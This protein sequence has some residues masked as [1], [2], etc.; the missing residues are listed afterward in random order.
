MKPIFFHCL[1]VYYKSKNLVIKFVNAINYSQWFFE[2][3][4]LH[5]LILKPD[6]VRNHFLC[7][8]LRDFSR[9][10]SACLNVLFFVDFMEFLRL[11]E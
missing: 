6:E 3:L 5:P 11:I 1:K 7:Y 2:F 9:L 8:S 4:H 10:G